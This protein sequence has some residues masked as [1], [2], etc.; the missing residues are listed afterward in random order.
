MYI[1]SKMYS[2][3]FTVN[4]TAIFDVMMYKIQRKNNLPLN[5]V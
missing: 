4:F 2:V 5:V 1:P 3:S